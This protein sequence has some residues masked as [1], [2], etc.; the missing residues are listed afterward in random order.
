MPDLLGFDAT[1]PLQ[2]P[3]L[4]RY[5]WAAIYVSGN[6]AERILPMSEQTAIP[7]HVALL[8]IAVV[9][10]DSPSGVRVGT[11]ATEGESDA[12]DFINVLLARGWKP[13][14]GAAFD[15]EY[16]CETRSG[17]ASYANAA[18]RKLRSAGFLSLPYGTSTILDSILEKDGEWL[19]YW[20]GGEQ[21]D[22]LTLYWRR[23]GPRFAWQTGETAPNADIDLCSPQF[24]ACLRGADPVGPTSQKFSNGFTCSGGFFQSWLH[25][26][27]LVAFG[28]PISA[29]YDTTGADG[30]PVR[31]QWYERALGEWRKDQWP[32]NWDVEYALL[33]SLLR[34]NASAL[35]LL[36]ADAQA[37]ADAFKAG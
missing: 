35:T 16:G 30:R 7:G 11:T 28:M 2:V 25:N 19:T 14:Q 24:Y 12:T 5:A 9:S 17:F 18:G 22:G 31:R 23:M 34:M 29:E 3:G 37:H 21:D 26:G 8:P 13:G 20:R 10:W 36:Y 27:G 1:V 32:A 4:D 6:Y 33:G 15:Y